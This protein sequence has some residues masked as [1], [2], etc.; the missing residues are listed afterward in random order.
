MNFNALHFTI[1]WSQCQGHNIH[2][3][4]TF[5]LNS[6]HWVDSSSL[7]HLC[8]PKKLCEIH[9]FVMV[10]YPLWRERSIFNQINSNISL[11]II[12]SVALFSGFFLNWHRRITEAHKHTE[13]KTHTTI[14]SDSTPKDSL[15][16]RSS[17]FPSFEISLPFER[18]SCTHNTQESVFLL[19]PSFTMTAGMQS[20]VY[21]HGWAC[22]REHNSW[23]IQHW[24]SCHFSEENP[25]DPASFFFL[26]ML[27]SS[28]A[29]LCCTLL[30]HLINHCFVFYCVCCKA[31][32]TCVLI[33][34]MQIN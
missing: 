11:Y 12:G 6:A 31:F 26:L 29:L 4:F 10:W 21:G 17:V 23:A 25:K 28:L 30:L 7:C 5:S 22:W 15:L 1:V 2:L 27:H 18:S 24:S 3:F 9:F 33:S 16:S 34:A 14:D 13:T 19:T 8:S 20:S 32:V